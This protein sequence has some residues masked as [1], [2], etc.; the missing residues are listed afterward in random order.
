M[1]VEV[2]HEGQNVLNPQFFFPFLSVNT[3]DY[4]LSTIP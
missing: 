1:F 2:F 4:E 3:I